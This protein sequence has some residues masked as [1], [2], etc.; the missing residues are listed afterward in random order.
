M[1]KIKKWKVIS[2]K[3]ISPSPWFPL[4]VDKVQL[5][6]GKIVDDYYLSH[7]G[8]V[9]M[10]LSITKKKEI[11]FVKQY[12]HGVGEILLELPAGRIG[13]DRSAEQAAKDELEEEVGVVAKEFSEIGE[14]LPSPSKDRTRVH[15]FLTTDVEIT[16]DQILD[17]TEDIEIVLIPIKDIDKKIKGGV[18]K[19]S[20][21]IALLSIA[22]KKFPEIFNFQ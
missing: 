3:D 21:T 7:L 5:P 17:E 2:E 20:D 1:S 14:V 22:K 8:D 16:K 12:K 4:F 10:I 19:A 9:A 18:I 15:G 11:I 13:R 6:N